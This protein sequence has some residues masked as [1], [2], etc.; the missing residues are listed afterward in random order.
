MPPRWRDAVSGHLL[1]P[2]MLKRVYG[3]TIGTKIVHKVWAP[4]VL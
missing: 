3:T 2:L 4:N 1:L